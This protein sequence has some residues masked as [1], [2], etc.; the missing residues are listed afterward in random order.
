LF[1]DI[2]TIIAEKCVNPE[3]RRPYTVTMIEKALRCVLA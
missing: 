1:R 3:T 2:A